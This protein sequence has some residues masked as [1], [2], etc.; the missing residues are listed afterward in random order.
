M[1][2]DA[3]KNGTYHRPNDE[4]LQIIWAKMPPERRECI[5]AVTCKIMDLLLEKTNPL[6]ALIVCK[7]VLP[8][9]DLMMNDDANKKNGIFHRPHRV[10]SPIRKNGN[11]VLPMDDGPSLAMRVAM[12]EEEVEKLKAQARKGTL[13]FIPPTVEEVR[14]YV[15]VNQIDVDAAAWH[16]YYASVGWTVGKKPMRNWQAA[17]RSWEARK[18]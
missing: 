1:K 15:H 2:D 7:T 12:L 8:S 13:R 16:S 4:E 11:P 9:V 10:L 5:H 3:S 14:E 17:V 6:E 18:R